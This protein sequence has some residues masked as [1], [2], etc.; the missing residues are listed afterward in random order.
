MKAYEIVSRH[1]EK[2]G[3]PKAELGRRVDIDQELLRR[4][5]AGE[6]KLTA[7][8]LVRLCVELEID[9]SEFIERQLNDGR[10]TT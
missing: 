1:V 7:D 10:N 8:E 5:L 6:R 2:R 4:S 3:I 9:F